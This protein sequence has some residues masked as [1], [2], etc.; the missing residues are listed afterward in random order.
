[1]ALNLDL[2]GSCS[3][4]LKNM[5]DLAK[6]NYAFNLGRKT[7]MLDFLTNPVNG[8]I[9][10]DL[11]NTQMG[12]KYV[13]TKLVYKQ[14]TKPCEI[15]TDDSVG[16]V[17]DTATEPAEVSV[18]ATITKRIGTRPK[19]FSNAKMINICQDTMGFIK[20][21]LV[22]DMRALREKANEVLLALVEAEGGIN[23]EFD[24]T[25][26]AAG[27]AKSINL[28]KAVNGLDVPDF[29]NFGYIKLDY[30]NNQLQG[31]PHIIGQGNIAR[32]M[33]LAKWTCCNGA[34]PYDNAIAQSGVAYYMDQAANSILG[35]NEFLVLAPNVTHLLWFNEN[36]N[37]GI[38]TDLAQHI[39]VPD[40]VYPA[41]KWDLD[42]KWDECDKA[43]IY[44]L[45]AWYDIFNAIPSDA[46][47][48]DSTDS[49]DCNDER[50]GMTGILKYTGAAS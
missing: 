28:I 7:G 35:S 23:Y 13:E 34:N 41:L 27:A 31:Y 2:A 19:K 50:I 9:K 12:K 42:F 46:F 8:S 29:A 26:T 40:P 22:S 16:D 15:L 10:L 43:W 24:G 32:F 33:D 49:P 44:K 17:C 6:Q 47:G 5:S 30:E 14:R 20:E 37:I 45:S 25:T 18:N 48:D 3:N 4:I 36:N 1:M 11:N 39:V 38:N 21:Y